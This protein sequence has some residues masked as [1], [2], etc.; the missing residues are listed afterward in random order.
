METDA[1]PS[2]TPSYGIIQGSN[3]F[4]DPFSP[5]ALLSTK[6][7]IRVRLLHITYSEEAFLDPWTTWLL[8]ANLEE[9]LPRRFLPLNFRFLHSHR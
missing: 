6:P 1:A 3:S 2:L 7:V 5:A 9:I 4:F 8:C